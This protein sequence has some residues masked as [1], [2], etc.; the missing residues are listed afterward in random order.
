[1]QAYWVERVLALQASSL[2]LV[3][4][5]L[6]NG[7]TVVAIDW[8]YSLLLVFYLLSQKSW[9]TVKVLIDVM[10]VSFLF[11]VLFE[12]FC[13]FFK[14]LYSFVQSGFDRCSG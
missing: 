9:Q 4:V 8:H 5:Y 13:Q 7:E 12:L 3:F 6:H 1:M 11:Q 14:H 2:E 10:Q